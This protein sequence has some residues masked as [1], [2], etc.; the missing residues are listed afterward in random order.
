MHD[1][2]ARPHPAG[3]PYNVV[4]MLGEDGW[5]VRGPR[6]TV[7]VSTNSERVTLL[8]NELNTAHQRG[9]DQGYAHALNEVEPTSP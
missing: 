4:A 5:Q 9:W 7:L 1:L 6:G 2:V 8:C 3:E